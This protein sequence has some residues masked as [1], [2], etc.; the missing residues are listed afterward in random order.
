MKQRFTSF[1]KA[2]HG[3][4]TDRK[5]SLHICDEPFQSVIILI[6]H[7]SLQPIFRALS[8]IR[9]I[10]ENEIK[11]V[12]DRREQV[13]LNDMSIREA[14]SVEIEPGVARGVRRYV[15]RND[16]PGSADSRKERDNPASGANLK[17]ALAVK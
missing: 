13:T 4:A 14:V 6:G 1:I 16:E 2:D 5:T 3:N 12:R 7:S 8:V 17:K 9:G 10:E 11:L 15:H